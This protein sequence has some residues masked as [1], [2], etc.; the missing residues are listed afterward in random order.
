MSETLPNKLHITLKIGKDNLSITVL[1]EIE[2]TFRRAARNI[3]E[4]IARYRESY[5]SLSY[6]KCLSMTLLD[7]AVYAIRATK[8]NSTAPYD[9]ALRELTSEVEAAL[10]LSNGD[11]ATPATTP[12][13]NQ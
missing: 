2:E 11:N 8:D 10:G 5:P 6:E 4:K 3:D 9:A 1:P 12:T 13:E 7:Y